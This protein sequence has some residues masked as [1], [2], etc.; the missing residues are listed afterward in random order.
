MPITFTN[1]AYSQIAVGISDVDTTIAVTGGH[2]ARFPA[3]GVGEYFYA[4]IENA[5]FQRE[6]VR[7]TARA[8]D[9]LTVVRGEDN[10]TAQAWL[11]GDSIALRF[12][13]AAVEAIRDETGAVLLSGNQTIADV[14]TFS[15]TIV[16]SVNGTAAN[17]TGTVAIAN[18]GTGQTTAPAA[19]TALK[20]AATDAATGVVELATAAEVQTGTDTERAVTPAGMKAGL[21]A[22]GT[23][24]TYAAR[25]WVNFNGTGVV[26][27]RASGNVSSITDNG[28]GDYTVNFTAALSDANYGYSLAGQ[29]PTTSVV[30]TVS[31]LFPG[32]QTTNAL[33]IITGNANANAVT[34]FPTVCVAVF[35]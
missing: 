30:A 6:I 26:A 16:G 34:D 3:L 7:V 25:A 13:A 4:T 8:T 14:K 9:S 33:R 22:T 12:N 28:T 27:I 31:Q 1:F 17:V 24:P 21:N 15:S 20:Q 23:A 10:T 18:G 29:Y 35:R 32:G 11:A 2:G 5:S 19:F